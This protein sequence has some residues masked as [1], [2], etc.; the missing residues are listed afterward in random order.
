VKPR[1]LFL[2]AFGACAFFASTATAGD[3][4]AACTPGV[5]SSGGVTFRTFCGPAHATAKTGGKTFRFAGGNCEVVGGFFTVN[6]GTVS[7]GARKPKYAYFGIDVQPPKAGAHS[8]QIVTF[9]FAGKRYSVLRASVVVKSGLHSGT[10]S[11]TVLTGG[12][13]TG[14][15]SC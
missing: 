5:R 6:I 9:S 3:T 2:A 4:S 7:L 12:R 13:A 14:S 11:G 15:F 10:F 8:N 1:A